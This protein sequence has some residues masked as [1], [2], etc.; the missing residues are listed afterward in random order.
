MGVAMGNI[1][2]AVE[3]DFRLGPWQVRPSLGMACRDGAEVKLE[4]RVLQTLIVL[5]R[6]DGRTVSRAELM[7]TAWGLEVGDDAI[8]RCIGKLRAVLA[9]DGVIGFETIPKIGYRLNVDGSIAEPVPELPELP[10]IT[11]KP[12]KRSLPLFWISIAGLAILAAAGSL[13]LTRD[14]GDTAPQAQVVPVTSDPGQEVQP[15]I[16]PGGGQIAYAS[17]RGGGRFDIWVQSLAGGTP[18][19]LTDDPTSDLSPAWSPDGGRLAFVRV[20]PTQ[21]CRLVV[22]PVPSGPERIVGSCTIF[23]EVKVAWL[24]NDRL[25]YADKQ[26]STAPSRLWSLPLSGPDAGTPK[27]LTEPPPGFN[28]DGDPALSPDGKRLAFM[29]HRAVGVSDVI[30][31]DLATGAE[32]QVTR[33]GRKLHG[34]EWSGDGRW[35]YTS[36]SRA[37]DFGLWRVDPDGREPQVRIAPGLNQLG[38]IG[39]GGDRVAAEVR[40]NRSTL[41]RLS[42]DGTQ[43]AMVP[44]SNRLD[45]DPDISA[46]GALAFASDRSGMFEIW[47][48]EPGQAP[49]PVT[50]FQGPFTQSP[51]WAPDGR[52][53][54]LVSTVDGAPGLFILDG[55]SGRLRQVAPDAGAEDRA[56]AWSRDGQRLYF[57]SNRLEGWRIWITRPPYDQAMPITEPGWRVAKES[58]D[59]RWL[60]MVKEGEG[61]LWRQLSDGGPAEKVADLPDAYDSESWVV[62][63]AGVYL[64][65]RP[66]NGLARI[67][68][69]PADG[70]PLRV[71]AELPDAL[72]KSSLALDPDGRLVVG[73]YLGAMV[74]IVD[75]RIGGR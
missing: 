34:L 61:G 32:T 31:R 68:L 8:G 54:A 70:G 7:R 60:Y 37:G 29:R 28:G 10:P 25:V 12:A 16:S 42:P 50:Q 27:P 55:T 75:V 49:A 38:R 52:R 67:L 11:P 39:A 48:A 14:G 62:G 1:D 65:E 26:S 2:L 57:A 45:W 66:G 20:D 69:L 41:L 13:I 40:I 23:R 56:P 43:D 64:V 63:P 15:A 72:T 71:A 18:V 74:D 17:D 59:G 24:D 53:L 44:P 3:P 4:P 21:P 22:Q 47:V 19:R 73:K 46:K 5:V 33:D 51:R 58:A 6:A 35:L 30:V 9:V 36:S